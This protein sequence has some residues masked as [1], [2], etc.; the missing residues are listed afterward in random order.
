M[1]MPAF[2]SERLKIAARRAAL[3][4]LSALLVSQGALAE[5]A[6]YIGWTRNTAAAPTGSPRGYAEYQNSC[7][8]CHGPMPGHPGTKALAAKYGTRLSA[9]LEE[10]TDLSPELIRAAVRRGMNMMPPLRKT[11]VS[12]A[13]LDAIVA[14]LTRARR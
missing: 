2:A 8:V 7:F 6:Q 14:Y 12:D 10:R 5:G 9:L 4:S 13:D 1:S 11:E 3:V